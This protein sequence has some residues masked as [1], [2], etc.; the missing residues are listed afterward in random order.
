MN[1]PSPVPGIRDSRTFHA[2]WKGSVTSGRSAVGMPTPSSSMATWSRSPSMRAEMVTT[3]A[4]GPY[5]KA[6]PTTL[7][8]IWPTRAPSTSIGGRSSGRSTT[9]RSARS[10]PARSP[11]RR[12]GERHEQD[13]CP[14]QDERVRL[15]V[16]HVQDL[17]HERGE[18]PGHL[19]DL[20]D[21][22]ALLARLQVEVEQGLRVP[23]DE[24][25]RRAQ[26]VADGGNEALAQLLERARRADVT[27]DAGRSRASASL[28][29]AG[30]CAQGHGRVP[31]GDHRPGHRR[32][33]GSPS[34]DRSPGARIP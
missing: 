16:G 4:G 7:S 31:A 20:L 18:A 21:V 23:S 12:V 24:R 22:L 28:R 32:H 29:S 27:Q 9:S 14:L 2:R 11:R 5:L 33:R 17:A 26:F 19:V 8:R 15:E 1:S 34:R 6:L 10:V 25:Q 30:R 13:R 3:P